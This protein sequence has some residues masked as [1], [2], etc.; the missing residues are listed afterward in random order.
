MKIRTAIFGVYVAASAVGF[1]IL[2][3]FVLREVRVRYVESMRHTLNDT[4]SLLAGLLEGELER[5][6]DPGDLGAVWRNSRPAFHRAAGTLRV[7]VTDARGLVVFDA[8][9]GRDVGRDYSLRPELR[10]PIGESYEGAEGT[11][12]V[13][14]ELRVAARVTPGG[15]LRGFVGV[16]RPLSSVTEAVTRARLWLAAGSLLVAAVL[17]A[18]GWW[19]AGRLTH[20]LERLTAY[21][22]AVRDGRPALPPGSRAAE[23]AALV[24]AFEEMRT[25]LE[26]KAYVERYTQALAH[27]F[28]A[29][30]SAIRGAAELLAENPPEPDRARF[31]A[32]LRA[33]SARLQ[34]IV[35]RLLELAA[36]ESRRAG[37]AMAPVDLAE[38]VREAAEAARAAAAERGLM[39]DTAISDASRVRGEKFLLVQ[40]VGN[41]LQNALEF[42][43]RGAT[44]T[45]T[46]RAAAGRAVVTVDDRGPGVPDYARDK[47]FDRFYSL[48][49]PDTGRKS[50]GIGL[51]IV[52]EV[53]RLHGGDATLQN[54][55][56]GG[57]RATLTL[58]LS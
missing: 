52:R 14:G 8:N 18:A 38:V 55:P 12:V 51:S 44:V 3:A 23:I 22:Q 1:A 4:A 53:A 26:G 2:M 16:A 27:E 32:N 57:A 49:R 31:L 42:S 33:E 9:G 7:Y 11:G 30:L 6:P 17:V 34:Q 47:I 50:S 40:A 54:R 46:L 35:E 15:V 13:D 37:A 28:K 39:L 24:R 20:S 29:P 25:T 5:Q 21:A 58:P 48:P 56:E 43:P 19:I 45:L 10:A 36:L 41:L